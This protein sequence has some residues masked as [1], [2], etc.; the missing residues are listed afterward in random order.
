L[1]S[2]DDLVVTLLYVL[3]GFVALKIFYVLGL[4]RRRS[5][6]E[7][8]LWSVLA[9][10]PLGAAA[11]TLWPATGQ[12]HVRIAIA[13]ALGAALGL[14]LVGLWHAAVR[15]WPDLILHTSARAWDSVLPQA[16]WVQ[17]WTNDG[18]VIS[19]APRVIAISSETD[20]LDLYLEQP[21]WVNP[22]TGD[23][24]EMT[25]VAGY[26]VPADSIAHVQVLS[27]G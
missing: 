10:A 22:E 6:L 13:L 15:R 25:G 16:Q 26:L 3:P 23:L 24:I 14:L 27:G 20:T 11:M 17:V 5:D 7:W 8:T 12:E 2:P 18:K 19:G 9:A 21:A 1:I 4:R